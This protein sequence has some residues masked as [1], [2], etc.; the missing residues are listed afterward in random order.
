MPVMAWAQRAP[1]NVATIVK[2]SADA[3]RA[4]WSAAPQFSYT[5]T[6]QQPDG[7]SKTYQV[8]MILGSPYNR[9]VAVNGEPLSPA[10]QRREQ[11]RMDAEIARRRAETPRQRAAR[12]RDYEKDRKRDGLFIDQLSLAFDFTFVDQGRLAGRE[13]YVLRAAPKPGYRP[14]VLEAEVLTG[15]R[16]KLWIDTATFQW[17]KVQAEVVHPVNIAG[18][19]ARVAPGT[20]FDL[21]YAPVEDGI[22]LPTHFVMHSRAKILMMVTRRRSADQTYSNYRRTS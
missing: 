3:N 10:E 20:R 11:L 14:P 4:D 18:F 9:L 12:T 21:D 8:A 16:G 17:V 2:R 6:D 13:V 15:M 22:W 5:E 1:V 19:L 7:G